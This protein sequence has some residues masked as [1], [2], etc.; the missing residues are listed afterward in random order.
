V[1]GTGD[2]GY[3]QL[4]NGT[5]DSS[6]NLIPMTMNGKTASAIS[7]GGF[8]TIV[9]MTDK[10]VW[11]TGYNGYGSLG[12]GTTTYVTTLT[13]MSGPY[14]AQVTYIMDMAGTLI[15]PVI[16]SIC[17]PANA[18]IQ[19]DQGII[20]ISQMNA[21]HTINGRRII[22]IT[23]TI[24]NDKYLIQFDKDALGVNYPT[25]TTV[26]SKEH[27]VYYNGKMIEAHKLEYLNN[28]YKIKYNGEPLYNV[29]METHYKMSVNNLI[30]ETLHPDNAVARI[31]THQPAT[32]KRKI[33]PLTFT[34]E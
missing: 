28:V 11:G 17:F 10:T 3:G 12:I 6:Y 8:F 5:T 23:K 32:N 20:I 34:T 22:A 33:Y 9:L 7:C 18:P 27:K 19:T 31:Y 21:Q 1:W 30:C 24:T 29:L 2:N 26:M 13:L 15:A 4:G 25:D 14:N 16:A